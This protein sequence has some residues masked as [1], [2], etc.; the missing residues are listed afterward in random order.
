MRGLIAL[1]PERA[2]LGEARLAAGGDAEDRVAARADDHRLGV[3][4]HRG[5]AEAG[6]GEG[7]GGQG[8]AQEASRGA[9]RASDRASGGAR[10]RHPHREAP[11]ALD[12]HEVGV[13]VLHQAFQ[14]VLALLVL[15][16]RVQKVF[17]EL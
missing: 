9:R 11:L 10:R 8:G 13:G 14:L 4:E 1:P 7:G 6:C 3:R 15:G 5:A 2:A 12:V 16:S 17:S